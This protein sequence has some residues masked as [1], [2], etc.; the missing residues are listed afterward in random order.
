MKKTKLEEFIEKR[1]NDEL[2]WNVTDKSNVYS[3]TD[4]TDCITVCYAADYCNQKNATNTI[5]MIERHEMVFDENWAENRELST[6]EFIVISGNN[7]I[8]EI[9]QYNVPK[10]LFF[11]FVQTALKSQIENNEDLL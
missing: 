7:K 4:R 6:Y 5:F 3:F 10:D 1:I 9:N 8:A 11:T 2:V